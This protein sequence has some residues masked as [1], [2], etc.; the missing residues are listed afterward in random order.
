MGPDLS[1]FGKKR[2]F[3]KNKEILGVS[4][5]IMKYLINVFLYKIISKIL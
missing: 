1:I 4:I 5:N 2:K 3:G